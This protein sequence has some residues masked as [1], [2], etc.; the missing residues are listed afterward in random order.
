MRLELK[1]AQTFESQKSLGIREEFAHVVKASTAHPTERIRG[2][3]VGREGRGF[4]FVSPKLNFLI[5]WF[6][7]HYCHSCSHYYSFTGKTM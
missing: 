7:Y 2:R 3:I 4:I 6:Y 5:Y 1:S